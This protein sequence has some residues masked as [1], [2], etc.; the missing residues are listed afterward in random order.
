MI[1]RIATEGQYELTGAALSKL[2]EI[3]NQLLESI[4]TSDDAQYK[5]GFAAVLNLVRS[6]GRRLRP[7]EFKESDVILPAP[8]TTLDEAKSLFADYPQ[9]LVRS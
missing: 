7:D 6:Q 4:R 1:I 5:A 3:D 2:D 9:D 8:D